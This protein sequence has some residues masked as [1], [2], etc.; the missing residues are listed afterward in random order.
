MTPHD[1]KCKA[2]RVLL[3]QKLRAQRK[4]ERES[5]RK[6]RVKE[7]EKLG[8]AA[9]AKQVPRT[10]EMMRREDETIVEADDQDFLDETNVDEFASYFE[11][12]PPRVAVTTNQQAAACCVNFAYLFE[13]ILPD[14]EYFP[15]KKFD[16]K[17]IVKFCTNREY[18]DLIVVNEDKGEINGLIVCHLPNGPTAHFKVTSVTMPDKIPGGGDMTSHKAELIVNNFTTRLGHTIGRMFASMFPQDPNFK[19]RRVCTVHNQ[20]DFIFFRQHRYM[21]E[22]NDKAY[23]QEL[24]PR[25]TM[26]LKSLQHG[27]FNTSSGEYIHVHKAGEGGEIL[28]K[29]YDASIIGGLI[30]AWLNTAPEAIFFVTALSSGNVRF[31]VG[32]LSGSSIVIGYNVV[33]GVVGVAFYLAFIA[34]SLTNKLPEDEKE[35]DLEVGLEEEEEEHEEP[36]AKGVGLLFLG[37][38]IICFFSKPFIDSIVTMATEMNVNPILLAFFLAPI[39]SEMPEIL[40]ISK[41]TIWLRIFLE[42]IKFSSAL[43]LSGT[44]LALGASGLS[45]IL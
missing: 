25:F 28:G 34:Y 40:E 4:K 14:A 20:R 5:A 15:R 31:A 33:I 32:A 22:A 2:R 29:K 38:S 41:F 18:T 3:T 11:G 17:E 1:I 43:W 39:A 19:G 27:T 37:G 36:L 30:I 10:I 12:K 35:D 8:D 42:L 26:K 16:M 21:F 44:M 24:G 23:L 45:S 6:E 9:P 13:K 7:R